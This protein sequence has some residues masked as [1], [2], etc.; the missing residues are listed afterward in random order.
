MP[1]DPRTTDALKALAQPIAEFRALIAA[2]LA[3]TEAYVREQSASA[4]DRTAT[5]RAELGAFANKRIDAARFATLFP[6]HGRACADALNGAREAVTELQSVRDRGD[7]LF[8]V[9]VPSGDSLAETVDAALAD[10]GRTFGAM[11]LSELIRSD[12][13]DAPK[14]D[15][16]LTA[17][18][19]E[20]WNKAE[21][22]VA[23]PLVVEV[24]GADL[25]AGDL[26]SFTDGR[27]KLVLVVRGACAPAPLA[28]CITPG[29]FVMQTVDGSGISR[30][31]AFDGPAIAAV[32]PEGSAIFMHDPAGGREP[33]QRLTV[34]HMPAAPARHIGG[35]STWQMKEDLRLLEDL[36]RTPFAVPA[37]SGAPVAAMGANDATDRI[38]QWLLDQSGLAGGAPRRSES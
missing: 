16:L 38:A 2:A 21:R 24:D 28:R 1:F 29:T 10:A 3:Q 27:V 20:T 23:P 12:R 33:W 32:V 8:A 30:L 37:G 26:A 22:R 17:P 11:M 13:Y 14:H 31:V 35:T 25:H 7:S 36:A 4:S 9:E 18:E 15:L 19:F 34:K 5:A 6:R